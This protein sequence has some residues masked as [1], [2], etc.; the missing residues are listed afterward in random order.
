MDKLS[1]DDLDEFHALKNIAFSSSVGS[2]KGL[3][4]SDSAAIQWALK[5][6]GRKFNHERFDELYRFAYSSDGLHLDDSASKKWA[7][8]H[9]NSSIDV[10][11]Y[12][13]YYQRAFS[14]SGLNFSQDKAKAWA[15]DNLEK[16]YLFNSMQSYCQIW[17]FVTYKIKG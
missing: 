4:L 14:S 11:R 3:N 2:L 17:C 7:F 6:L 15:L 12:K 9:L 1:P 5:W 8:E 16:V 13:E 10:G